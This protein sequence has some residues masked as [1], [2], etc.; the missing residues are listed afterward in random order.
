MSKPS[1]TIVYRTIDSAGVEEHTLTMWFFRRLQFG[2][3]C[4]RR[5][6]VGDVP[7][8][9]DRGSLPD[10]NFFQNTRNAIAAQLARETDAEFIGSR[11]VANGREI[12]DHLDREANA[13]LAFDRLADGDA[14]WAREEQALREAAEKARREP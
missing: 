6:Y 12:M 9:R 11:S 14:W 4:H 5:Q 8:Q 2:I 10:E 13:R 1:L 3:A 7:G